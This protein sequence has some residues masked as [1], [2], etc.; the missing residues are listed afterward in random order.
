[1]FQTTGGK[2]APLEDCR[3]Q[4]F[5]H[6][7]KTASHTGATAEAAIIPDIVS[8]VMQAMHPMLQQLFQNQ[9][10]MLEQLAAQMKD[11]K[12]ELSDLKSARGSY[13][14]LSKRFTGK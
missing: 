10:T 11:L 1:M 13:P 9:Q 2:F 8:G 6:Q 5:E 7:P 14:I 3:W 12:Q 4:N